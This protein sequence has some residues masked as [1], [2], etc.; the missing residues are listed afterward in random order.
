[1]KL[2]T[3]QL[4]EFEKEGWIFLP[5]VFSQKEIN[6]LMQEV[7]NIFAMQREEVWREKNGKSVRTA[8]AAHTYNEAFRTLAAFQSAFCLHLHLECPLNYFPNNTD[9]ST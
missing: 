6:V 8:F 5:D 3:Q 7:P 1:M 2:N 9:Y 4:T